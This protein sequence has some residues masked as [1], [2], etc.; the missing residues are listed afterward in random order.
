MKGEKSMLVETKNYKEY[1]KDI[2]FLTKLLNEYDNKGLKVLIDRSCN[3]VYEMFYY[4]EKFRKL[5][6][7]DIEPDLKEKIQDI[8]NKLNTILDNYTN[9]ELKFILKNHSL[10]DSIK[11]LDKEKYKDSENKCTYTVKRDISPIELY[12]K[13]KKY[14]ILS[15]FCFF[16][17]LLYFGEGILK[18]VSNILQINFNYALVYI[19]FVFIFF[20]LSFREAINLLFLSFPILIGQ[21]WK[22]YKGEI[23]DELYKYS[24]GEEV[25]EYEPD[26]VK[27]VHYLLKRLKSEGKYDIRVQLYENMAKRRKRYQSVFIG[28]VNIEMLYEE[29]LNEKMLDE[30][31]SNKEMLDEEVLNNSNPSCS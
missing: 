14:F 24:E 4:S 23:V 5:L 21:T 31:V 2:D 25:E 16:P 3:Y 30:E 18:F 6:D 20:L 11:K 19:C 7:T 22:D 29:M 9:S 1:L 13:R 28:L 8:Y 17:F 26:K 10:S 27:Y 12:I 15:L